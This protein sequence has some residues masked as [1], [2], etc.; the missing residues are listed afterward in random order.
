MKMLYETKSDLDTQATVKRSAHISMCSTRNRSAHAMS[1]ELEG[2]AGDDGRRF[3]AFSKEMGQR[4]RIRLR[5]AAT[6]S[7]QRFWM[8]RANGKGLYCQCLGESR[9]ES[10]G[11]SREQQGC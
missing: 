4:T 7:C 5:R 1:M 11:W 2:E 9:N 6:T 8:F 10:K 3:R